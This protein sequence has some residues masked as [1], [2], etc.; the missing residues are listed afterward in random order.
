VNFARK[1]LSVL[2]R[3]SIMVAIG[4]TFFLGLASTVYL[5]L[6][7]PEVR[8]PEVVGKDR[9]EAEKVLDE[10]G[11]K[12][13]IRATRPSNQ[14]QPDTILFQLPR[15]GEVVKAGQTVAMDVSRAAREGEASEGEAIDKKV[16]EVQAG[17]NANTSLSE[18]KPKRPKP[19]NKNANENANG[20]ANSDVA[21]RNANSNRASTANRNVNSADANGNANT[22]G[23]GTGRSS[24]RNNN[25]KEER[26]VPSPRPAP[27]A[28]NA[29]SQ[30]P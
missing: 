13:R 4:L 22:A 14:S 29:N 11:L 21:N 20:N 18:N 19:A 8:V 25:Q 16:A 24:N 23:E 17:E 3:L 28:R 26:R 12:Y 27:P 5:S 2:R 15:A 7:S 6:R 30:D 10:A 1:V 9:F